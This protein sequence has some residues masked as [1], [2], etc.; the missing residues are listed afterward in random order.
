MWLQL[1]LRSKTQ[2]DPRNL[3]PAA[4]WRFI[5]RGLAD[6][7][8]CDRH[9]IIICCADNRERFVASVP[10]EFPGEVIKITAIVDP[11]Q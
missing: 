3:L 9:L 1:S 5:A 2:C 10:L 7:A 11:G 8:N 4:V 6:G